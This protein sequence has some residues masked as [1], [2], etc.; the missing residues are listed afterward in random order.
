M[1]RTLFRLLRGSIC[2]MALLGAF[3]PAQATP[4][5]ANNYTGPSNGDLTNPA[6]W[7][8]GHVP[9]VSEDAVF[10][11]DPGTR[12]LSAAELTVGSFNV[13]ASTGTFSMRN[14]TASSTN[15]T[16][17]LGGAGNLGNGVSGTAADLLYA[18][19]GSTFNI[20]GANGSTGTGVLN[21]VLGQSG[22]FHAA[23]TINISAAISDGGGNFGISKTGAGILTLSGTN[24]YTGITTINGGTLVLG[25]ATNTLADN[26]F[27][28]IVSGTLSLGNN[29]DT[30][31]NVTLETGSITSTGGTLTSTNYD[32]HSGAV[33]A[34]LAG[35]G[36]TLFKSESGT[37]S[38]TGINTYDGGTTIND[39]DVTF[40]NSSALGT[41]TITFGS[42]AFGFGSS[43]LISTAAVSLSNNIVV[44]NEGSANPN[45]TTTIGSFSNSAVGTNA[46]TGNIALSNSLIIRSSSPTS[47]ALAFSG[48]ISGSG[49]VTINPSG[50][51]SPGAV[52]LAGNNTYTGDTSI[53]AGT[54]LVT[55]G[56]VGSTTNSAT[57]TGNVTVTGTGTTL[58]G[59]STDG[60][61]G[62]I[63][64][65]VNIGSNSKLSPGTSG[66]GAT[67]TAILNTGALTLSSGSTFSLNLNNTAAGSGY[68]QVISSG[69]ITLSGST[70]A[71][72]VGGSLQLNDMFFILENSSLSLN[73]PGTFTNG[74]TVTSGGYTFAI[75]YAD[76]G[77][78]TLGNDI[79]LEVIAVPEPSTWIVG[80]LALLAVGYTQRRKLRPRA[81]DA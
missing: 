74:A 57:G 5:T 24:T 42:N 27:I 53:S 69:A 47:N 18:A 3:V 20:I 48:V 25:N 77:D 71:V 46:Y 4:N 50:T 31:G 21:L 44:V 58:A 70:L 40:N 22:N 15:S 17:T 49:S 55:G 60:A 68:D 29:N 39:G 73:P 34:N 51:V 28:D 8:L 10:T 66:N 26:N 12:T 11:D 45:R 75:D 63:L 62:S 6:N 64:G 14:E 65:T 43:S 59:G 61:T 56:V 33:T 79:S 80:A 36:T 41:G 72:T 19:T 67:T 13:T 30:V 35:S 38:L 2:F 52:K 32:F 7:S 81:T 54:L 1:N 9:T 76:T 16:L 23:G 37:L 78:G